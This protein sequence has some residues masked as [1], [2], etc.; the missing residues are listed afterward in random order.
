MNLSIVV[1]NWKIVHRRYVR[2]R[3]AT[4]TKQLSVQVANSSEIVSAQQ[5]PI[6]VSETQ[7]EYGSIKHALR[8]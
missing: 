2:A 8:K 6:N 3:S 7:Q 1:K 5:I 4:S